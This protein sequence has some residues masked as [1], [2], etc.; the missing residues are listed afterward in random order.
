MCCAAG[1]DAG[2]VVRREAIARAADGFDDFGVADRLGLATEGAATGGNSGASRQVGG[3]YRI[4]PSDTV[5][6]TL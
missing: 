6:V 3:S 2:E 1:G 5:G 4:R